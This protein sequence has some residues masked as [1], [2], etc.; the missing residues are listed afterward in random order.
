MHH[1][2]EPSAI[3]YRLLS[4]LVVSYWPLELLQAKSGSTR[5]KQERRSLRVVDIRMGSG[6][7]PLAL[8]GLH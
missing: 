1:L 3:S 6:H 5:R 7:W 2:V 4:A 8:T